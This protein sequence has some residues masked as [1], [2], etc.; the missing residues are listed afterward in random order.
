MARAIIQDSDDEFD[1]EDLEKNG[2]EP[3]QAPITE[4]APPKQVTP[5]PQLGTDSTGPLGKEFEAA[6]RA[7]F[8]SQTDQGAASLSTQDVSS[9]SP[10]QPGHDCRRRKTESAASAGH[11]S[12]S[13]LDA[14]K[15]LKTYG[16]SKT[17]LSSPFLPQALLEDEGPGRNAWGLEGTMREDYVR[18][19]PMAM[20]PEQS[21]TIPNATLTQQRLLAEVMDPAFL[22]IDI[23]TV[24]DLPRQ[25]LAKSSI[26]WSDFIKSPSEDTQTRPATGP[27]HAASDHAAVNQ[28]EYASASIAGKGMAETSA[29]TSQAIRISQRSRR[30]SSVHLRGSPLRNI[31]HPE[32]INTRATPTKPAPAKAQSIDGPTSAHSSQASL[33]KTGALTDSRN[34]V[35]SQGSEEMDSRIL[36]SG[37]AK[38]RKHPVLEWEEDLE[39]IGLPKERYKP[40]PSRS[41]SLR[42]DVEACVDYSVKP[43]K[44]AKRARRSKTLNEADDTDMNNTPK[45]VQ[46]I[47]D[48]GF[49]PSTTQEALRKNDG[50]VSRTVDWL[51]TNDEF[52]P[53]PRSRLQSNAKQTRST[54]KS[55]VESGSEPIREASLIQESVVAN[56]VANDPSHTI[57]IVN[58]ADSHD[59]TDP[60][61]PCEPCEP[62]STSPNSSTVQ[63][64]I[65]KPKASTAGDPK[66]KGTQAMVPPEIDASSRKPKRRKTTL[67]VPDPSNE[68]PQ[69]I[70]LDP[71]K[72]KKRGRGRPRKEAIAPPTT[73]TGPDKQDASHE[74]AT[75]QASK[76]QSILQDTQ[77]KVTSAT[78]APEARVAEEQLKATSPTIELPASTPLSHVTPD[79]PKPAKTPERQSRSATPAST[80]SK[81][82]APYRVG[83]SKRARIAPLLRVVKK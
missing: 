34:H 46:Q 60:C 32:D 38:K 21:S 29:P 74:S 48:M 41:R 16:R 71:G 80:L 56:A 23:D 45:K 10:F 39:D 7:H 58:H 69:S 14:N 27:D 37:R 54:S 78:D 8:Q 62:L 5:T 2:N 20:F 43:E 4:D 77:P 61:E 12:N 15:P 18:H 72:G 79:P 82:K 22:G 83:L 70:A 1:E 47:C 57:A 6:H 3:V 66:E 51:V 11:S 52:A 76:S 40:R 65:P 31:V 75:V 19:E 28:E 53:S 13:I 9:R 25:E 63:V 55:R 36:S 49:S 59:V 50:D 26:P 44:A 24:T 67:D 73:A 17:L 30:E 68:S 33:T 81:G 42:T 64:V 35:H